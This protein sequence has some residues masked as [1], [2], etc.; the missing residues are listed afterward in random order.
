MEVRIIIKIRGQDCIDNFPFTIRITAEDAVDL[1]Y[2][3]L[4]LT[5]AYRREHAGEDSTEPPDGG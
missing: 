1:A 5:D 2:K 3:L 4:A